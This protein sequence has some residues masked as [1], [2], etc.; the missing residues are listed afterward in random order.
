MHSRWNQTWL[1]VAASQ[2]NNDGWVWDDATWILCSSFIIFTMQTGF[3]M[4]ESG[5]VSLKNEVNIMMK[6][7]VDVV[8]GG[9]T[10][11]ALG[12]GLSYGSGPG[13]NPFFGFGD[14]FVNANGKDIGPV[15]TTFLFQLSFATT[16]T[17]IV[18]GGIGERCNFNAYCIFS[19]L[20]TFV[21]CI[22]AGWLWGKHG[23][24]K[25]LG[26]IDIAGSGGVHLVGGTSGGCALVSLRES[27]IIGAIGAFLA[28]IS[29]PLLIWMKVDD[30]VGATCVHGFGGL[31][32]MLAVGLFARTDHLEGV[33]QHAGLFHG[34]GFYLLGVQG[35]CCVCFMLWSS[36]ATL[37]LIK[38]ID[39][40]VHFRMTEIQELVGADYCEHNIFHSGVGV[41]RAVS[42][43]KRHD[44]AVDLGL[45]PVGK[46]KGHMDFLERE[47]ASKLKSEVE[48]Y[49]N[50]SNFQ[51][52]SNR[53]HVFDTS[54]C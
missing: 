18:S 34:G 20:N 22:P 51:R 27:V 47:Y 48:K 7:V 11:W 28:N 15:F 54:A 38:I 8:F 53:V 23:F 9:I 50:R 49:T 5:C 35:L 52:Q 36:I 4:L 19:L 25:N 39:K 32:G 37:I 21:Y 10:Y 12:Y 24:L 44:K 33:S 31:W 41:T 1:K 45:V 42:V 40:F 17:T 3:G 16:A 43:I 2:D 46:N 14:W 29:A 30:A 13:T 6:N 26:A